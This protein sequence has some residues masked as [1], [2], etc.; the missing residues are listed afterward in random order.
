[1]GLLPE[2]ER[3]PQQGS[4]AGGSGAGAQGLGAGAS[5]PSTT[6]AAERGP[7]SSAHLPE[8]WKPREPGRRG[9]EPG[10]ALA[11]SHRQYGSLVQTNFLPANFFFFE[12]AWLLVPAKSEGLNRGDGPKTVG[13]A[14]KDEANRTARGKRQDRKIELRETKAVD[15]SPTLPRRDSIWGTVL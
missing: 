4:G 5:V 14:F 9:W 2:E 3:D 8:R 12:W 6:R 11:H 13:D 10:T 15:I 7:R 1:M